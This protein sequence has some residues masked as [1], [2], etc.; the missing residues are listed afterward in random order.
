MLVPQPIGLRIALFVETS[1]ADSP[2]RGIYAITLT[3]YWVQLW[4]YVISEAHISIHLSRGV[5]V[6]L[7]LTNSFEVAKF[8][9]CQ[10]QSVQKTPFSICSFLPSG[11]WSH[12]ATIHL[13]KQFSAIMSLGRICL[14]DVM[15]TRGYDKRTAQSFAPLSW[16]CKDMNKF[17]YEQRIWR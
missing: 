14:V 10:N 8:I 13:P 12:K 5:P 15:A 2:T 17:W 6:A 11:K 4:L 3:D 1:N 16:R 7:F 9:G